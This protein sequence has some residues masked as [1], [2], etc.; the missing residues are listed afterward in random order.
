MVTWLLLRAGGSDHNA[1]RGTYD[2]GADAEA[3]QKEPKMIYIHSCINILLGAHILFC[4][5]TA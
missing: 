5:H 2:A 4:K 3:G 1:A